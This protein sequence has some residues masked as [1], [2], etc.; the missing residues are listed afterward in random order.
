MQEDAEGPVGPA[1]SS[2][3]PFILYSLYRRVTLKLCSPFEIH[4]VPP[5]L[6]NVLP[7]VLA[8]PRFRSFVFV[9][10]N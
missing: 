8:D 2:E 7:A 4:A 9:E 10:S 3:R 6:L 5:F 1:G